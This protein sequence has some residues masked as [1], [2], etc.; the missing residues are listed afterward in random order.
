MNPFVPVLHLHGTGVLSMPYSFIGRM[1][2]EI[3]VNVVSITI[4]CRDWL[5]G[6]T[7]L[8]GRMDE[9]AVEGHSGSPAQSQA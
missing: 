2:M 1:L 6:V 5:A 8:L 4:L 9:L 3:A 7:L